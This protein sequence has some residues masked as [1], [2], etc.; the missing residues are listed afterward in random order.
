MPKDWSTGEGLGQEGTL[1][2][3]GVQAGQR[4]QPDE[5]QRP[6]K[7]HRHPSRSSAGRRVA[8]PPGASTYS[9]RAHRQSEP[10]WQEPSLVSERSRPGQVRKRDFPVFSFIFL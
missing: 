3:D 9:T 2:L 8:R 7:R 5:D 4:E 10:F 6:E 1:T